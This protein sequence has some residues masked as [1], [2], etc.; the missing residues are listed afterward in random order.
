MNEKYEQI[1][2]DIT[3]AQKLINEKRPFDEKQLPQL[4]KFYRAETTWSSN[5]IEGNSITLGETQLI[6][7]SGITVH[8]HTLNEINECVGHGEA[9]DYMFSLI[10]NNVISEED[11]KKLHYIFAR[12]IKD[13]PNPGEYRNI[14]KTYVY[15]T[16]SNYSCPD[17][18]KVPELMTELVDW[19][20][21]VKNELHP[22]ERAAEFHR[23]FVYIHPF[24]D[25]NG[26]VAR[27][28][29]NMLLLQDRYMPI[30]I[31]PKIRS[32][33]IKKLED[34]R[35][36]PTDFDMFI[37][38]QEAKQQIRFMKLLGIVK[39]EQKNK[40]KKNPIQKKK[41]PSKDDDFGRS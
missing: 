20:N 21:S 4:K 13:I 17:F 26:R 25:G 8:G 31:S 39:E 18:D 35:A 19:T 2:K 5:A 6:L 37:A 23:R 22:V 10:N 40:T 32:T 41:S 14:S 29:M 30:L 7:E 12:N 11:I 34:G 38:R 9:F 3:S 24:P 33:Y 16:G 36:F 28:M 1:L 15:I 27:L